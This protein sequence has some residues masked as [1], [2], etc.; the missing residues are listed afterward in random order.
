MRI[1]S[2]GALVVGI[3][4]FGIAFLNLTNRADENAFWLLALL[5][6]G[7][8]GGAVARGLRSGTH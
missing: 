3:T 1:D 4:V 6:V 5:G 2:L 7:L 8:I